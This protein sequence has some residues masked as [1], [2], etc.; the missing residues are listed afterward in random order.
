MRSE[1]YCSWVCLSVGMCVSSIKSHLWSVCLSWKHSHTQRAMKVKNL[2][3]YAWNNCIQELIMRWNT[4][5]KASML[6][7]LA[8]PQ[9]AFS[10][11]RTVKRQRLPND[12]QQHSA[13]SQ[14][15]AYW[16]F[17]RAREGEF[18]FI[19]QYPSAFHYTLQIYPAADLLF[20]I[21][22]VVAINAPGS[23][24]HCRSVS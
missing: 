21:H 15:N 6:I 13:L 20:C 17:V 5:E 7:F 23:I 14:N 11:W 18:R 24:D 10:A 1:G 2:W 19:L 9:S 4:S 12:C 3:G 8:Y 22:I 16:C